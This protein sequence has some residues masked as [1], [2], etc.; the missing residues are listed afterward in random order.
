MNPEATNRPAQ[1][2]PRVSI[3]MLTYNRPQFIGRA[4]QSIVEQKFPSWELIIVQDGDHQLTSSIVQQWSAREPRIGYFRR[5]QPGNI[6]N[7][8]N[9]G[10]SRASGEYI[11]ILDDDDR[12]ATRDK[13]GKQVAFLDTH[14]DYC[15]IGGG[16]IVVDENGN[17]TLR[18]FK[19]EQDGD[20]KRHA[21]YAN[22][23][24]HSTVMFRR[25]AGESVGFYDESLAGFQDWDLWLKLGG[26]GKLHNAPEY[27]VYYT[28][29]SG[30]GSFMQQRGNTASA[31][32]IVRRH[33]G[34]YPGSWAAYSLAWMY[35][36]YAHLPMPIKRSTYSVLS[37]LKK[38]L[39][40]ARPQRNPT[41]A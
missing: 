28:L 22:P 10:I 5:N 16:V 39:T 2:P 33:S 35:H 15:A 40:G 30:G 12:W 18:Y 41:V 9:Y 3:I 1:T 25:A 37:R 38:H 11:A 17:T 34:Q 8:L 4:I 31:L 7:A 20:I 23:M 36:C 26:V 19:P 6:A 24:A 14:P 13:L 29:W 32:R 27:L 21:L